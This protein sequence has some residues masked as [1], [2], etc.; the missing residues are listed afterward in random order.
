MKQINPNI[1]PKDGYFFKDSDGSNHAANSWPGVIARV[2]RYRA[3]QGRPVDTV[4]SEVIFQACV[5]NPV[6]CVEDNGVT[7]AKQLEASL[8]TRVL[9]WLTRLRGVKEKA[10]LRYV[11]PDLHAARTDVCIR[12]SLDKTLP[13]GCSSCRAALTA[14]REELVGRRLTDARITACPALG[15][16]LPVSTWLDFPVVENS[17]IP[18]ECWRKKTI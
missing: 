17:A 16:Y 3:R 1:Y 9:H 4:E 15:E 6:L 18:G 7:K 5:R 10:G 13:E 12:C 14:L 8:K 11:S 2:T